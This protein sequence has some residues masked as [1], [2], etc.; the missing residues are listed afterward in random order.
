MSELLLL[1][2]ARRDVVGID[3]A[4]RQGD[5]TATVWL[6]N[7]FTPYRDREIACFLCDT[8]VPP[9]EPIYSSIV[10]DLADAEKCVAVPL[11]ADCGELPQMLK[12]SRVLKMLRKMHK[13]R[14]GKDL[15]F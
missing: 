10:G 8:P 4:A 14:T 12:W 11:C 15:H 2:L 3:R 5:Q 1:S 7:L 6:E 13:A 9:A